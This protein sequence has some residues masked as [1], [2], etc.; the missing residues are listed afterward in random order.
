MKTDNTF[1]LHPNS[2]VQTPET[3]GMAA[4]LKALEKKATI[5]AY[6]SQSSP[7]ALRQDAQQ[8][9]LVE[10]SGTSGPP[11]T[12]QR[13][14]ATWIAS[15]EITRDRFAISQADCYATLGSL[16][17]S[18]SL[19]ATLEALHIGADVCALYAL[20]PR[21][22][23][24]LLAEYGTTV[25]YATPTQLRLLV[26]AAGYTDGLPKIRFIFSGGGKLDPALGRSLEVL[27][28][29]A[30]VVEFFGA[31]ETSF[32]SLTD[33]N[34][35]V[36]SVGRPYPNV[37]LRIGSTDQPFQTD[38]IWIASPYLFDGYATGATFDTKWDGVFLS[39]GEMGY[40]DDDGYLF[41]NGRKNR[42]VTMAD[43]NVFPEEI[44]QTIKQ[45]DGVGS[46]AVITV[47]DTMRGHRIICFLTASHGS[48]T[49]KVLRQHCR[50]ALNPQ[51]MPKDFIILE[52]MPLLAAGKPDLTKLHALLE[53]SP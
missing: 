11:K 40:V 35:P 52:E 9:L 28:P 51:A 41:L 26:A 36:G 39:I 19:F 31:S 17:H 47:P 16:G 32:I 30:V 12:I 8:C 44:E 33:R 15:F 5:L 20:K 22:K 2:T 49:D 21:Q 25:L 37:T 6:Q 13:Q 27:C 38:E 29:A 7:V 18:L 53:R 10:T 48:L 24:E 46:C 1:F 50:N 3:A 4:L 42:M 14:P 43:Q 23:L 45:F 34:T